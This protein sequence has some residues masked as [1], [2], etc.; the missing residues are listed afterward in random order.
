ME[1]PD[2]FRRYHQK[3]FSNRYGGFFRELRLAGYRHAIRVNTLKSSMRDVKRFLA[4][5]NIE[6]G[7]VP[8]CED[9]LWV[10]SPQMNTLEHQLGM[11]Y[12]QSPS[13]M[14]APQLLSGGSNALDLCA[15]PGGKATHISQL[16]RNRGSLLANE[17]DRSRIKALV[18]NLQRMGVSNARVTAGDA[19]RPHLMGSGFDR[20][21]VDVPCSGVGT[22]AKSTEILSK[23]SMDWVRRLCALQK[24]MIIAAFDRLAPSGL[25]AYTTCTTTLEENERVVSHLLNSRDDAVLKPWS[26]PGL[27]PDPPKDD[28]LIGCARLSPEKD[29]IEPHFIA[30]VM[31]DG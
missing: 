23:W 11:Y 31:R 7:G 16:M 15:A 6:Y 1:Y 18:H 27:H 5:D 22:L 3:L 13:S 26:L 14:I 28:S 19:A 25:M 20:I 21:L 17:R 2:E 10:S 9:G 8:W 12:I 24:K 29:G 30:L 4:K